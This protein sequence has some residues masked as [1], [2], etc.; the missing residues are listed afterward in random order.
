MLFTTGSLAVTAEKQAGL[1]KI[2][3]GT[4]AQVIIKLVEITNLECK[5]FYKLVA[6]PGEKTIA[7]KI[8]SFIS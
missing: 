7:L 3:P 4:A 2:F 1:Y 8:R 5:L 6:K